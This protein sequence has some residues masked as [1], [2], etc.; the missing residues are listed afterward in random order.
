MGP[1]LRFRMCLLETGVAGDCG[2]DCDESWVS[3]RCLLK[4]GSAV[5]GFDAVLVGFAL[6]PGAAPDARPAPLPV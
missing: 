2:S 6:R 3:T 5:R 1:T 4:L